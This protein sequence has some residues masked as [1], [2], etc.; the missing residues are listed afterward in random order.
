MAQRGGGLLSK[1]GG[2][3]AALLVVGPLLAW[4]R[5]VP[6]MVGFLL[7]VVGGLGSIVIAI[8][9]IVQ[10]ARGRGLGRGGM[11]AIA[12]GVFFMVIASL[13]RG[14]PPI[15]DFTTDLADPPVYVHAAEL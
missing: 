7:F 3:L 6:A 4:L 8:I 11:V 10:A 1:L 2:M 5:L 14:A 15:N 13:D 9:A 12:G